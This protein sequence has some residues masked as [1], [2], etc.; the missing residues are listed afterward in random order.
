MDLHG[1]GGIKQLNAGQAL[2]I[3]PEVHPLHTLGHAQGDL[4]SQIGVQGALIGHSD[5]ITSS[6]L[7]LSFMT[8]LLTTVIG[9]RDHMAQGLSQ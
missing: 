3:L 2:Y 8:P 9:H 6:K 4:W 7:W 1:K 5:H